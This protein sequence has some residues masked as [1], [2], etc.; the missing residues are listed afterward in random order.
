MAGFLRL[1]RGKWIPPYDPQDS[2][3]GRT[4]IITGANSG[5]GFEAAIK[6]VSL[7]ASRVILAVRDISKGEAARNAIERRTNRQNVVDVWSLDMNSYASIKAFMIRVEQEAEQLDY[8]LLNA[9]ISNPSFVMGEHGWE[10]TLQVNT[11]STALLG[12]LM[13]QNLKNSLSRSGAVKP[14]L[15]ITSSGTHVRAEVTPE[16]RQAGNILESYN[17]PEAYSGQRQYGLSKLFIQLFV[18]HLA[19]MASNV[20][21]EP[22]VIVT[23]VCPGQLV[24]INSNIGTDVF[25]V[26][27]ILAWAETITASSTKF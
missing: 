13:F 22:D 20:V 6:F 25:Q 19:N 10:Q 21:G 3:D 4:V 8:V 26:L 7:G 18:I 15:Q 5:V 24:A 17:T 9:G 27:S 11:L 2:F 16:H 14:V 1:F 23:S 12:L